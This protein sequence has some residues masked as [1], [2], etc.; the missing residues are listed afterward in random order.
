VFKSILV[1]LD[2]SIQ[3]G[4]AIRY[5][6][7]LARRF[8]AT[9]TGLHVVDSKVLEAPYLVDLSGMTGAVPFTGMLSEIRQSLERRGEQLLEEFRQVC[10]RAGLQPRTQ[11]ETGVVAKCISQVSMSHDLL[12]MGRKSED[13]E[14]AGHLL[15][16]TLESTL[17]RI[18][19]PA[20]L[21]GDLFREIRRILVAFD[22]SVFANAAL[23]G[24]IQLVQACGVECTILAIGP[25][26][27]EASPLLED[28]R[29][30]LRAHEVAYSELVR[31]GDPRE[32]I[33]AAARE[34]DADLVAMGAFGHS[35]LREVLLG[36][37][38]DA[39]MRS[40]PLPLLIART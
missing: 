38:T 6:I 7:E 37:T 35:R 11:L 36:S 30:L 32:Q 4:I 23:R 25:H 26:E 31:A 39:V 10:G 19:V 24:A 13:L 34:I 18:H 1:P 17:R 22:G 8:E 5:A 21:A 40:C 27:D 16:S 12:C 3:S 2:G 29:R 20:L 28:A 14:W 15:G 33:V 9:L